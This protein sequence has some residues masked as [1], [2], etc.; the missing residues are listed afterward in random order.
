MGC[1]NH[2]HIVVLQDSLKG[3]LI[4][5]VLGSNT[6]SAQKL[7]E[8]MTKVLDTLI[9]SENVSWAI[10]RYDECLTTYKEKYPYMLT[11]CSLGAVMWLAL[12]H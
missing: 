4:S 2:N 3:P 8:Y 11:L 7:A 5:Y 1:V 9:I 12:E 6:F 10:F